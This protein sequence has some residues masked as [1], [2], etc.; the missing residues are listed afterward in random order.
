MDLIDKKE[1]MKEDFAHYRKT[2]Q[3]MG[4]NVP[5]EVMCLPKEIENILIKRGFSRVYDLIGLDLTKI[6]GLGDSRV[7]ILS[8]A[9]D[10]FITVSI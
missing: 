9:L 7:D 2:L 4:G 5:V 8:A 6:K 10:E 1:Q 3:Y